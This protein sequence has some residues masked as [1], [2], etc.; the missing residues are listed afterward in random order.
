MSVPDFT[1]LIPARHASSRLPGKPLRLLAGRPMIEHV[2]NRAR[3]SGASRVVVATDD[4]RI[5]RACE[6]FGA[7]CLMTAAAHVSGTDRLAEAVGLLGLADDAVVVNL[8]GDEPLMPPCLLRAAA[9]AL[10]DAPMATL[11]VPITDVG[12]LASPHAVK[13]VV[14]A[15]G[16]ALYFSRAPIPFDRDR[17]DEHGRPAPGF[18][19]KG[20]GYLRHLGIYAY[21]AAFLHRFTALAPCEAERRESLEQLRALWW[22]HRI[23]VAVVDQRPPPGVDTEADLDRAH[24]ALGG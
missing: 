6:R 15:G 4:R 5:L 7:E 9:A 10:G 22:G 18:E 1:V 14:D 24:A 13:V 21:R 8:Q 20:S 3:E 19:L 16:N 11:A 2:H 12:E 17:F 23:R